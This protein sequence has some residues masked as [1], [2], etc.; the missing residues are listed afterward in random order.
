MVGLG[1]RDL[2]NLLP[3]ARVVNQR[4]K[5][6]RI[7]SASVLNEAKPRIMA[8]WQDGY[9]AASPVLR[10]RFT[11]EARTTLPIGRDGGLDLEDLFQAL[12]F[13]RLRLRQE[14]QMAEWAGRAG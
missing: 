7:V 11:E 12:D 5:R 2:W 4:Q 1:V 13:R 9:L 8:W 14:T 10:A 3:A 6:D